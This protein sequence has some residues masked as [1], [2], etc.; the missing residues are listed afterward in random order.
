MNVEPKPSHIFSKR[1]ASI[2]RL[3]FCG[4]GSALRQVT[5]EDIILCSD[6][7]PCGRETI[8]HCTVT[9][10]LRLDSLPEHIQAQ[11]LP[12]TCSHSTTIYLA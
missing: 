5:D 6:G 3:A 8:F 11:C 9:E 12:E 7:W 2:P 1:E 10:L 4:D